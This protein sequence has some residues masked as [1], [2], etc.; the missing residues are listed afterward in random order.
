MIEGIAPILAAPF[1]ENGEVDYAGFENM[2]T[3]FTKLKVETLCLFGIATEFYKLADDEKAKLVDIFLQEHLNSEGTKIKKVVSITDHSYEIAVK[4]AKELEAKQV[5][6]IMIFPP[7]FLKP[8]KEA[9]VEHI[10][11]I[12]EAVETPIIIQYAP[13]QSGVSIEPQVFSELTDRYQN[14]KIVKVE[15]QPP[16]KYF[17]KLRALDE[18]IEGLVGYEGI[19]MPDFTARGGRGVQP[20]CSFVEI[21]LKLWDLLI[22]GEQAQFDDLFNR[23]AIYTSYWMQHVELIIQVEKEILYRRGIISSPYCRRPYY[24]LDEREMATIDQFMLEFEEEMR[25]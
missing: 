7:H 19:Q 22:A 11:K 21:Y 6:W 5:D 18:R 4:R 20:G 13:S 25:G 8:S 17:T 14:I 16:G 23:L 24:Q 12:A 2:L 15:T 1:L 10:S 3:H 9:I